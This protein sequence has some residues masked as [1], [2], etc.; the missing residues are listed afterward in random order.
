[1]FHVI[2]V[3][4]IQHP[5]WRVDLRFWKRGNQLSRALKPSKFGMLTPKI[6]H[7]WKEITF[8]QGPSFWVWYIYVSFLWCINVP[9]LLLRTGICFWLYVYFFW[10][11]VSTHV[12]GKSCGKTRLMIVGALMYVSHLSGNHWQAGSTERL[13]RISGVRWG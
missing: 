11:D 10:V 3:V 12:S 6:A 7:I 4:T 13:S 5:G 1:M 2:L 9:P 8:F